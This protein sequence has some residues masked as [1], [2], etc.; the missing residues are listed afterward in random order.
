MRWLASEVCPVRDHARVSRDLAGAFFELCASHVELL[1][2]I[3]C[4]SGNESSIGS[5]PPQMIL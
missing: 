1:S 4:C 3:D 5:S 2:A